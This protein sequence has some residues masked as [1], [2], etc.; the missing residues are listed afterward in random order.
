LERSFTGGTGLTRRFS[1]CCDESVAAQTN[2]TYVS[3]RVR[4]FL[5]PP[6]PAFVPAPHSP[7]VVVRPIRLS[8]DEHGACEDQ[9]PRREGV[10]HM[11]TSLFSYYLLVQQ[12]MMKARGGLK[13]STNTKRYQG[14]GH[15]RCVQVRRRWSWP[16]RSSEIEA[17]LPTPLADSTRVEWASPLPRCAYPRVSSCLR[18]LCPPLVALAML[19]PPELSVPRE[20]R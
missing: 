4:S 18:S 11:S 8:R 16:G 5:H 1:Q 3:T 6:P 10:Q 12:G 13:C 2:H 17:T 20:K 7:H 19:R 9:N 15:A 14:S